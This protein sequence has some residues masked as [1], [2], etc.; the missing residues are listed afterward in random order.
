VR[1]DDAMMVASNAF[2]DGCGDGDVH[3]LL[4]G[5]LAEVTER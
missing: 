5:A 2:R 1:L 4:A 3:A